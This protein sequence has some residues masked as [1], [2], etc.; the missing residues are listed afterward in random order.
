M[1]A[2]QQVLGK[3]RAGI[4]VHPTS[5]PGF[6]PV[7]TMGA[8]AFNFV[9]YMAESGLSV[10]Q[11]L[12]LGPVGVGGSPY[13]CRS[14]FAGDWRLIDLEPFVACGWLSSAEAENGQRDIQSFSQ[15]LDQAADGFFQIA[16]ETEREQYQTFVCCQESWLEDYALFEA[17]SAEQGDQSWMEWPEALRLRYPDDLAQARERLDSAINRIIFRQY[18]F[19][20]QWRQLRI[21][22][23]SK[24]IV[25]FGDIPFFVSQNSA[26]VWQHRELF[27]LD[28]Q[29]YPVAVS[30][31]P[32]DYFSSLGQRWGN[33]LYQWDVMAQDHYNWWI[34]RI[35][36]QLELMDILRIDHFRGF[37]AYWRI[38]AYCADAREGEWILG[39][40]AE[41]F[42]QLSR[43]LGKLPLVAEDLGDITP[44]VIELRDAFELPGMEVMQFAFNGGEHNPHLLHHH[45]RQSI[46]YTGTHDNN[47]IMG[48]W[49]EEATSHQKESLMAYMAYPSESMPWPMIKLALSSTSIL[50]IVPWQDWLAL[51]S[52]ARMNIPGVS[53]GQWNWRFQWEMVPSGL[54]HQCRGL[55]ALYDRIL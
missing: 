26:D 10:W 44:R 42:A 41:F 45:H 22:A 35:H 5:L 15:A 50:A 30:G 9:D 39:P 31:V 37:E 29:S 40:G 12:P 21:Y 53:E 17:I 24:G 6:G 52:E 7:G 38:P 32:P 43:Q 1:K 25:F 13:D 34:R 11:I 27:D 28:D 16:D 48:W 55:L 33:P 54:V 46:V 20:S 3:R 2:V 4:L 36:I 19:F 51:G 8:E 47:T 49:Q 18:Q 14:A 23:H